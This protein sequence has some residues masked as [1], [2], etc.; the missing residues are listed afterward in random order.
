MDFQ[1]YCPQGH[2]LQGTADQAGQQC[3]CPYC[4]TV[5]VIPAPSAPAPG[6]PAPGLPAPGLPAPAAPV[7]AQEAFP[8]LN[9]PGAAPSGDE[10][11]FPSVAGPQ[12]GEEPADFSLANKPDPNRIVHIICPEGHEL[13]TPMSMIGQEAMCP[14][15]SALFRLRYEDSK[16]SKQEREQDAKQREVEFGEKALKWAIVAAVIIGVG[17]VGILVVIAFR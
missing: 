13:P 7:A 16:E 17:L 9:A 15:C 6:P 4:Q 2:L 8:Q 10:S 11:A 12:P 1:F 3:Q 14:H 5:F